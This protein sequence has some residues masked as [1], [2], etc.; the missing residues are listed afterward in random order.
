[1]TDPFSIHVGSLRNGS[2]D[3]GGTGEP[4]PIQKGIRALLSFQSRNENFCARSRRSRDCAEAYGSTPHKESRGSTPRLLE[5]AI[6][7]WERASDY[8]RIS[9]D[10]FQVKRMFESIAP[11]YDFQNTF[12][13][14]GRDMSWRKTLSRHIRAGKGALVLDA[15]TGTGELC[16]EICM[17]WPAVHAIGVDFSPRMLA[18][19]KKKIGRKPLKSRTSL[20]LGDGRLLPLKSDS[21]DVVTMAFGIR[22]IKERRQ[23]LAEFSRVLKRGGQLLLMEFGYPN[24]RV[25]GPIYRFYFEHVLPPLG[26]WISRTNYAYT[27]LVQSVHDFPD[28]EE[29]CRE[30]EETGFRMRTLRE[31]TFGIAKIYEGIKTVD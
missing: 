1:M 16:F 26:N 29:F 28:E 2:Q 15:A 17:H 25:L 18:V 7:G 24:H 6:Y 31:L 22:N 9:M 19:A 30:I 10:S 14:L 8:D 20:A 5:K 4:V 12:L 3:S 21:I 13:S 27:Y 23:V 11:S